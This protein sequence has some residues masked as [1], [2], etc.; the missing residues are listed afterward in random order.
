MSSQSKPSL[1]DRVRRAA[2]MVLTTVLGV[3]LM[4]A[5]A[6]A[7][8]SKSDFPPK[9]VVKSVIG[10]KSAWRAYPGDIATLGGKP[11]R[12]RSDKQ[13]LKFDE[14]K[15]KLF[16]GKERGAPKSVFASAEIAILK[17]ATVGSAR[18][19]VKR[20][21]TYPKRCGKV[22]EWVCNECDG[23]S[24]TRRTRVSAAP[25]GSQSVVWKFRRIDNFK[26][27]GYAVVARKGSTV[28]RVTVSRTRDVSANNGWVYPKLIQKPVAVKLARTAL[29]DAT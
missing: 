18:D 27:N 20:N 12:C 22:T 6:V 1:G 25:V 24:T 9:S 8:I 23:I 2:L 7:T 26:S 28:V 5:P 13:M 15:S 3:A 4:P 29:S 10:G 21:G 14:V 11:R 16:S 19:A 17:Y